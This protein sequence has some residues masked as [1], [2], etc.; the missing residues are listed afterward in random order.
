MSKP[1]GPSCGKGNAKATNS[2]KRIQTIY[3][4]FK[5]EEMNLNE[6][7][8]NQ[9]RIRPFYWIK[10]T[11]R[12]HKQMK[13]YKIPHHSFKRNSQISTE[14]RI[15]LEVTNTELQVENSWLKL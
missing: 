5:L 8:I 2:C 7:Y 10:N 15:Y 12:R 9:K 4:F 3:T 6:D 1:N 13:E 11:F 14:L